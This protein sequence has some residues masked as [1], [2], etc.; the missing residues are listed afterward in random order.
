MNE[1]RGRR[2][3]GR[4]P[5]PS[6][7]SP[8]A[9][10]ASASATTDAMVESRLDNGIRVLSEKIPGVRSAAVG[11]WIRQGAA[12]E[13]A[14]QTGVSHLLEHMVFKGTAKR[15]ALEIADA[16]EGLG[17]SLDAYTSREHTSYQARVLDEHLPE[18]LDVLADLVLAPRLDDADLALEREVV[19]EEI[20][21]VEDTPDDLVFEL[22]GHRLWGEHSYGR[23]I[24]GTND[25]VTSMPR[26]TLRAIHSDRYVG[27]NLVVAAAGNVDHDDFVDRVEGLFGGLGRG[28][29]A[30]VVSAPPETTT[31]V[32]IVERPTAQTHIVFGTAAPGHSHEDRY[33]LI[34]L[35]SALGGGMSSRLFQRVR[36]EL[37][38]CYSVF[39]YQNFFGVAGVTGVYVGTRPGT[40]EQA[41]AAVREE[42]TRVATEGLSASDLDRIKRQLKGQVMLSLES[43][44]SRLYRLASFALH[45]E[46]FRGLDDVLERIDSVSEADIRR[47]GERFF[48]PTRHLELRLGPADSRDA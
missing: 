32:E 25:S 45:E 5:V 30:A 47:V 28:A 8:T 43:T 21:Q 38:L 26:D 36:E 20:A 33:A 42:M 27:D 15:S 10:P 4:A 6:P 22:H 41:A 40:A 7:I 9:E 31:G 16:L 13:T 11:V 23:S 39:T 3:H 44:G 34:L 18:A 46:P 29:R 37:G 2:G 17:G 35:S 48:D 1:A 14:V 19:L 12:H 24:L